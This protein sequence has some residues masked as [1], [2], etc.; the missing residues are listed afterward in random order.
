[1]RSIDLTQAELEGMYHKINALARVGDK[2][3]AA[4]DVFKNWLH[5]QPLPDAIV[6]GANVGYYSMRP[7]QGHSL[8]YSQVTHTHTHTHTYIYIISIHV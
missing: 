8:S 3:T 1:M 4:F 6:D 2:Q 5:R 7:D